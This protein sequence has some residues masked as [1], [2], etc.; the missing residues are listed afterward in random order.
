V[1]HVTTFLSCS[2]PKTLPVFQNILTQRQ[3]EFSNGGVD[4]YNMYVVT[5]STD[6][7]KPSTDSFLY[8][9]ALEKHCD[10]AISLNIHVVNFK[11]FEREL[12]RLC[13]QIARPTSRPEASAPPDS[14]IA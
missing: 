2:L 14:L 8:I 7:S 10:V 6:R 9:I 1:F 5:I 3:R 13:L 12:H 11:N 4:S